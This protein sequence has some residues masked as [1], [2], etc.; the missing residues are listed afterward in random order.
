LDRFLAQLTTSILENPL[1]DNGAMCIGL[2]AAASIILS[3]KI[4]EIRPLCASNF[5]HFQVAEL[6]E[7]ERR[8]L[9]MIGFQIIPQATPSACA[10]NLLQLWPDLDHWSALAPARPTRPQI[11]SAAEV[12]I[13]HFFAD[14]ESLKY[15]PSTIALAALLLTFSKLNMDCTAWLRHVPDACFP[16][17]SGTHPVF[18]P[19]DWSFLDV[20]G[21]LTAMQKIH[22]QGGLGEPTG[23]ECAAGSS[24]GSSAGSGVS[25]GSLGPNAGSRGRSRAGSMGSKRRGAVGRGNP[26]DRLTPTSTSELANDHEA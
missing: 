16:S 17:K 2:A 1:K 12:L 21:C 26:S 3:S 22:G 19:E 4:H 20:D 13:G 23:A 14:L 9:L 18:G 10:R 15:A 25:A 7:I 5:P 11:L 6:I 24:A 8:L